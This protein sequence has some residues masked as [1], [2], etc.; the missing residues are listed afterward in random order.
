MD[1][2]RNDGLKDVSPDTLAKLDINYTARNDVL[3]TR[4]F[5]RDSEVAAKFC[6]RFGLATG[7]LN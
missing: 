3:V 5:I 7:L 1:S 6:A 4:V 2:D